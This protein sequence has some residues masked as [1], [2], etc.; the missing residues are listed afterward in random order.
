MRLND[1]PEE[2]GS[3]AIPLRAVMNVTG[4]IRDPLN[5]G[6]GTLGFAPAGREEF[7]SPDHIVDQQQAAFETV[8][9][10][11]RGRGLDS[12]LRDEKAHLA[13]I[14]RKAERRLVTSTG[15]RMLTHWAGIQLRRRSPSRG[16]V[17]NKVVKIEGVERA[18]SEREPDLGI[19]PSQD[20][21]LGL[22][23]MDS[24]RLPPLGLNSTLTQLT[25]L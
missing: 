12:S 7:V 8:G 6:G 25:P 18:N 2:Q 24:C 9:V 20:C 14:E 10:R 19:S 1:R 3:S 16:A 4:S 5:V 11:R 21:H 13:K 22:A 17:K 15:G 23:E